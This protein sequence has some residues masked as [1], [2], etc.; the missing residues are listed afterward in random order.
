MF[1]VIKKH[2]IIFSLLMI[3]TIVMLSLQNNGTAY[4]SVF[5]NVQP[6]R[7][8]P[9]YQVETLENKVAISFDAAWG[10]DKTE[11]IM[12]VLKE[13]NA[14]ATFFLVGFWV[15]KYS[16]VT[17]KIA[18]NGFEIGSHSTSHLD[19]AKIGESEVRE[20]LEQSIETIKTVSGVTPTVFRPPY[21]SYNNTLISVASSLGLTSVQWS[22]DTLDWK[23]LSAHEIVNRVDAKVTNGSIILCHNNADNVVEATKLI[24]VLLQQ[25][26]L[27]CVSV[28]ELLLDGETYV[29]NLGI[30]RKK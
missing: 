15:D 10:A 25:K 7:L 9:V 20:D 6:S 19:M 1:I 26:N 29:D 24:M 2:Q 8:V 14:N 5:F 16:E 27:K 13:Y 4:A 30:Q 28:S 3:F 18:L 12:E 22:I 23:G 11:Q 17:K 21:G